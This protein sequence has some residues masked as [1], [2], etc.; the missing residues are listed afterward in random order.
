MRYAFTGLSISRAG[1]VACWVLKLTRM[2][3]PVDLFG[4]SEFRAAGPGFWERFLNSESVSELSDLEKLLA[5]C[6]II[7]A[8]DG[9]NLLLA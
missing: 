9:T 2:N 3:E 5:G 1:A 6:E 4:Q 7:A 8:L